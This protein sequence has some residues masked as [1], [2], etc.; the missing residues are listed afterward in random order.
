MDIVLNQ[1]NE[2]F[3]SYGFKGGTSSTAIENLSQINIFVG[4]NNSGK[5]RLMRELVR[6]FSQK[7]PP[8]KDMRSLVEP[9]PNYKNILINPIS[10]NDYQSIIQELIEEYNLSYSI[11][12]KDLVETKEKSIQDKGN[13]IQ[14]FSTL[15]EVDKFPTYNEY[16]SISNNLNQEIRNTI[17]FYKKVGAERDKFASQ[18]DNYNLKL[19][20]L[21]GKEDL[22]YN[23]C[24]IP[25]LRTLRKL[26]KND[27]LE[28]HFQDFYFKENGTPLGIQVF[29]G[30]NLSGDI[31][32]LYVGFEDDR[33]KKKAF[34]NFLSEN[35]YASQKIEITPV[36]TSRHLEIK[37]GNEKEFPIHELG[38]GIQAIILL[39]FPLFQ[40]QDK[41]FLLFIEE[42][43]Q[44]LHPAFQRI[45]IET[46]KQFPK[47]KVFFTTHSNH[48]LDMVLEDEND[49]S[50]YAFQKNEKVTDDGKKFTVTNV[51]NP[52]NNLLQ[53]LGVRSSSVFLS[54]CT[55]WVE[56][57][58]DRFYIRKY[59]KLYQE[60]EHIKKVYREDLHF[61][62]VEYGGNN[63]THWSF[64][65]D[66]HEG[67]D[68][69]NIGV[70]FLCSKSCLIADNDGADEKDTAKKKKA[71]RLIE[72][73]KFFKE[74]FFDLKVREIENLLSPHILKA[75]LKALDKAKKVNDWSVFD[76][77]EIKDYQKEKIGSFIDNKIGFP[78]FASDS[79]S[80]KDK[81]KFAIA[82]TKSME[83]YQDLSEEAQNIAKSV[84]EFIEQMNN[85][86]TVIS[87]AKKKTT[88]KVNELI[89]E[90]QAGNMTDEDAKRLLKTL[91]TKSK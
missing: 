21:F 18:I 88:S 13:A 17:F 68:Y 39:A 45:F 64:L 50:I 23:S 7:I 38:D 79:G 10:K 40:S 87:E 25:I 75:T 83:N 14:F 2:V 55:I 86:N 52:D 28:R 41:D 58:T 12:L 66:Q 74:R 9:K 34:E 46:I 35:F 76:N 8:N 85:P 48:F 90:I 1:E 19:K 84:Y 82:A 5:S 51:T 3:K 37:V 63:I 4:A 6:C 47:A 57:I 30:E 73:K 70:E 89:T 33:G 72:L 59:L 61:S 65:E 77:I 80:I 43:E 67:E 56:G 78:R 24:Y 11:Y 31:Y 69:K 42:P 44:N 27:A 29:T 36:E 20:E 54:N 26:D 60:Q 71:D 16:Y 15:L 32:R 62:F 53:Q 22:V 49:I 81:V 91:S